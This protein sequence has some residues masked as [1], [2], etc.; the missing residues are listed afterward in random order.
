[1]TW[2]LHVL[3]LLHQLE[4]RSLEAEQEGVSVDL[5]NGRSMKLATMMNDLP[6]CI[7]VV[8]RLP[9]WRN[10]GDL[11]RVYSYNHV[12]AHSPISPT[13]EVKQ[14]RGPQIASMG[15][16]VLAPYKLPHSS[17]K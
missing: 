2:E 8:T 17:S 11:L 12:I 5:V 3:L 10:K 1:M 4:Y 16:K 13:V 6:K 15:E 14:V 9:A 7:S